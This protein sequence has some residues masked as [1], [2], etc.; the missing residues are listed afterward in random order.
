MGIVVD[1]FAGG[2]GWSSGIERATNRSPDIAVNHDAEAVAMHAVNH[3]NTE[4][5]CGNVWDYAPQEVARGRSVDYLHASPTCTFFSRAKGGPLD[6][7]VATRT[8]SLAWVVNRYAKEVRPAVITVENVDAFEKWGPLDNDGRV[9]PA[10]VGLT[11]RRW[12]RSLNQSGYQVEWRQLRACDYGAPTTRNRLFVIARRDG[13]PIVWPAASHGPG[14]RPH[15][16]AHECIEWHHPTRSVFDRSK[17]LATPTMRRIARALHRH[18]LGVNPFVVPHEGAIATLIQ[19]GYGEREGQV[20]R[21]LDIRKP[22]G[23]VVAGGS[24][25]AIVLACLVKHFG[26]PSNGGYGVGMRAPFSTVTCRDHHA[27]VTAVA[28]RDVDP[29]KVQRV[30][31]LLAMGDGETGSQLRL[32]GSVEP[33]VYV[34][35]EAFIIGDVQM[36]MMRARELFNAQGF[37]DDYIIDPVVDGAPLGETA[38]VRMAGNSVPPPVAEAIVREN[39]PEAQ[40]I[41]A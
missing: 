39:V 38:Q 3:P 7:K 11:F 33:V 6:R 21:A 25:H 8:R 30:R 23:T 29:Q 17:P 36:R 20:P 41:A 12:V 24:K 34:N 26:G 18:V 1:L 16:A 14:L 32:D 27:L 2:G 31:E 10:K 35:G 37:D 5:L 40:E 15:R 22:L 9:Q 4:H 19:T 13:R 28:A